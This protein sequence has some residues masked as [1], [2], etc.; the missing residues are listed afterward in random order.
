M[1]NWYLIGLLILAAIGV[2]LLIRRNKQTTGGLSDPHRL[3]PLQGDYVQ[4]R[5][6]ARLANMSAEDRAWETSA[7]Q[8][9][10]TNQER[11]S[12]TGK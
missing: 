3:P 12:A 7:L 8:R 6:T 1:S 10:Q 4:N 2:L 5:E 11:L 9:N